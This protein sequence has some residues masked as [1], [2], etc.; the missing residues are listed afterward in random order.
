M[1]GVIPT[2]GES[3]PPLPLEGEGVG[4]WGAAPAASSMSSE[5]QV[6]PP[7][8]PLERSGPTPSQPS[9][10]EG[11]GYRKPRRIKPG[12][13]AR[14][15]R[16]RAQPTRAEA[17]LWQRL[18][19]S[20]VRFHRQAPIGPYVVDFACHR[21]RLVVEVDGGVHQLTDVALRDIRRDERLAA[22]GYRVL[23]FT[24]RQVNEQPEAVCAA[25]RAALPPGFQSRD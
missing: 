4:G 6:R 11:E 10:L 2:S 22:E 5:A 21:A 13:I 8:P 19:L 9:P 7:A 1:M 20:P 15:R 14:G 24:N 16:L 3:A 23:R 25:V 12:G 18:R 17:E